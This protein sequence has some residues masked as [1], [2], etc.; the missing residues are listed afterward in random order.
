MLHIKRFIVKDKLYLR[1]KKIKLILIFIE[2]NITKM[3]SLQRN[4][5]VKLL[6]VLLVLLG[7]FNLITLIIMPTKIKSLPTI[8]VSRIF[9][10]VTSTRIGF[11]LP[12]FDFLCQYDSLYYSNEKVSET[13]LE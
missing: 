5:F 13:A 3:F 6:I 8:S 7:V 1:I 11:F 9:C 12:T 10:I 2:L 4:L